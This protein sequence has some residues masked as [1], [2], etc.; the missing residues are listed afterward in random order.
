MTFT[1]GIFVNISQIN[2]HIGANISENSFRNSRRSFK[3]PPIWFR[4]IWRPNGI[5]PR[6]VEL[7]TF[8][9]IVSLVSM[10]ACVPILPGR[11]HDLGAEARGVVF[12]PLDPQPAA[13]T[14]H[15]VMPQTQAQSPAAAAFARMVRDNPGVRP[16]RQR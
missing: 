14:V 7:D 4:P 11:L 1:A 3:L 15:L 13:R 10:N 2:P 12:R 6:R 16:A 9:A 8:A 5:A